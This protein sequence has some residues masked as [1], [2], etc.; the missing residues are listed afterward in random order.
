MPQEEWTGCDDSSKNDNKPHRYGTTCV[1][2]RGR[3]AG[4]KNRKRGEEIRQDNFESRMICPS[5]HLNVGPEETAGK[6]AKAELAHTGER[7]Q[8]QGVADLTRHSGPGRGD[9][10]RRRVSRARKKKNSSIS[11]IISGSMLRPDRARNDFRPKQ[12]VDRSRP[13]AL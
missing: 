4:K 2:L 6:E 1:S 11:S 10:I 12:A 9:I 7:P 8:V 3:N 13:V 5:E